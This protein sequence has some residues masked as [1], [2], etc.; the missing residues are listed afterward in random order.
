MLT[1]QEMCFSLRHTCMTSILDFASSIWVE[2]FLF[3]AASLTSQAFLMRA[4][5]P[6]PELERSSLRVS[7]SSEA[8]DSCTSVTES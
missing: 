1:K 3:T 2:F 5:L 4:S 6:A 8:A 7:L